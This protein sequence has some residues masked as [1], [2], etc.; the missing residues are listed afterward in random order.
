MKTFHSSGT[1]IGMPDR[2]AEMEADHRVTRMV[3]G[4]PP[5]GE[6]Q[7]IGTPI[8]TAV[9]TWANTG[10][11]HPAERSS[12]ILKN[13]RLR[14]RGRF[15]RAVRHHR[16]HNERKCRVSFDVAAPIQIIRHQFRSDITFTPPKRNATVSD[17]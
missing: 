17:A 13:A 5:V 9:L 10:R 7:T 3:V 11:G 4:R 12:G 8:S 2:D 15:H 6:E 14:A 1:P 16:G